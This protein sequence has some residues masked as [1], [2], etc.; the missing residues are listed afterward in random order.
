[1][2]SKLKKL[3]EAINYQDDNNELEESTLSK[4]QIE[5]DNTWDFIINSNNL[6]SIDTYKKLLMHLKES[7]T[8]VNDVILKIELTKEDN[9]NISL[10][11]EDIIN[12]LANINSKYNVF[13]NRNI[14]IKD[15]TLNIDIYN[16]VEKDDIKKASKYIIFFYYIIYINN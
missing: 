3:L 5:K 14:N 7:F 4:I 2:S 8:E 9:N 12:S 6:L 16:I 15:S 11:F 1:M 10:Y 13:K